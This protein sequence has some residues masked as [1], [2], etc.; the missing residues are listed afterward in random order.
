MHH[1]GNAPQDRFADGALYIGGRLTRGT[2]G[3][4]HT[5]VDPASA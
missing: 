1:P 5:V 2:S 4:T 3:R